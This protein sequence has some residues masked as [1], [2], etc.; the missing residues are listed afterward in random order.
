MDCPTVLR[1]RIHHAGQYLWCGVVPDCAALHRN[2][3]R[4]RGRNLGRRIGLWMESLLFG[5]TG[6]HWTA[7]S[8]LTI[9]WIIA[10]FGVVLWFPETAGIGAGGNVLAPGWLITKDCGGRGGGEGGEG[11]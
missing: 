6:S 7:V 4:D 8:L 3:H 1:Y 5:F 2:Q 9:A 11:G 10:P